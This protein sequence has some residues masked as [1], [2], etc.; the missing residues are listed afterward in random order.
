MRRSRPR[1]TL[2]TW[3]VVH[4]DGLPPFGD[5]VPCVAAVVDLAEGP[6]VRTRIVDVPERELRPDVELTV[7]F[8][9]GED[10]VAAPAFTA[11]PSQ[12]PS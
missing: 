10:G 11:P 2:S 1:A 3:S 12:A 4:R 9:T 5:R 6:R 7:A 8:R